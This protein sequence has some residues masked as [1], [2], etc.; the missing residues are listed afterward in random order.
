MFFGLLSGDIVRDERKEYEGEINAR[1]RFYSVCVCTVAPG[2]YAHASGHAQRGHG[3]VYIEVL[4]GKIGNHAGRD[5]LG[6]SVSVRRCARS[7]YGIALKVHL[8]HFAGPHLLPW[9]SLRHPLYVDVY[10]N[11]L[12]P[13]V[14]VL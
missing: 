2:A 5:T 6:Y 4:R 14:R 3:P 1:G 7:L 13:H 8:F 9:L 10:L 11:E 12:S